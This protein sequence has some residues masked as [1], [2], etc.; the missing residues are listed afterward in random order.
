MKFKTV[1]NSIK[2]SVGIKC[3]NVIS[4]NSKSRWKIP[5]MVGCDPCQFW[6][7]HFPRC[8][9]NGFTKFLCIKWTKEMELISARWHRL[10]LCNESWYIMF[11]KNTIAWCMQP[12]C[13]NKLRKRLF[14]AAVGLER[15]V[16]LSWGQNKN[17]QRYNNWPWFWIQI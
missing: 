5:I 11:N 14:R 7:K 15:I 12:H 6:K 9:E 8:S 13:T 16:K 3:Y 2:C 1:S 17:E 10:G 4:E